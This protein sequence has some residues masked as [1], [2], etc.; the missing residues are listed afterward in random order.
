MT[1]V[2][3]CIW[4]RRITVGYF[5]HFFGDARNEKEVFLATIMRE[6]FMV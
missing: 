5:L 4:R 3:V 1:K 6:F 2:G